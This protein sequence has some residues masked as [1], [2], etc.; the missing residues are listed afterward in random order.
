MAF[1]PQ[2]V[3]GP[4]F[5]TGYALQINTRHFSSALPDAGG[6]GQGAG[7]TQGRSRSSDPC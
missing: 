7:K 5:S 1:P 4:C 6:V 2:A 3:L